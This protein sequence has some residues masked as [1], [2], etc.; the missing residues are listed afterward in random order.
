[1]LLVVAIGVLVCAN[2]A[3]CS[4]TSAKAEPSTTQLQDPRSVA[5][6]FLRLAHVSLNQFYQAQERAHLAIRKETRNCPTKPPARP[7]LTLRLARVRA[8]V[9]ALRTAQY[10]A[11]PYHTIRLRIAAIRT[12][13]P[14]LRR[15]TR[16]V[17]GIDLEQRQLATLDM[18]WCGYLVAWKQRG[19]TFDGEKRLYHERLRKSRFDSVR[20]GRLVNDLAERRPALVRLGLSEQD[21]LFAVTALSGGVY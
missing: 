10:D 5:K 16:D 20:A 12:A 4:R 9:E 15:I 7:A 2:I 8:S 6:A 1:M 13:D 19:W 14:S 18:N 3:A 17:I 11:R 21:A